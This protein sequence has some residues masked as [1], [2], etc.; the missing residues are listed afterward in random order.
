MSV[1]WRN[2]LIS[3]VAISALVVGGSLV[4]QMEA[5]DRGILPID[6]SGTLE[7]GGV[8]VDVGAKDA[9]GARYAGWRIAQREGFKALW[10][11]TNGRPIG[12]APS[13]S[14]QVLDSL[15]ASIVI[16][17]EQIGP[18]RY[19]A[20]L[21]ILFDRTRA[22]AL[23]GFGGVQ[24]RSAP[25]LLIPL[26]ISAGS[27]TAVELKNVW[28]RAWA[29]YRTAQSAVDYVRVSGLGADPLLINAAQSARPGRGWWRN[30]LDLYGASNVLVAE[31]KLHRS[32]PGGPAKGVFNARFG[33]DG[34]PLGSFELAAKD[35]ADIPRMMAAGVERM[36]AL[37]IRAL[38]AGRFVHDRSLDPPPPPPPP[39]EELVVEKIAVATAIDVP[40]LVT[41]PDAATLSAIIANIRGA[42]GVSGVTE[43]SVALGG[44]SSLMVNYRGSIAQLRAALVARGWAVEEVGGFLRLSVAPQRPAPAKPAAPPAAPAPTGN[45]ATP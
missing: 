33:P 30:L 27:A 29:Q 31:V 5:G 25:M 8:H 41:A 6:S 45:T 1:P 26:T 39:V 43:R 7:I 22:G 16:E 4:A 12:E 19:I 9:A 3:A 10:A 24:S 2:A 34:E 17:R 38:A 42:G 32:Y 36:D 28:Q 23:L 37:F 21:G 13:L 40:L 20:D 15:V 14:D 35:S 11:R 18:N 44:Q